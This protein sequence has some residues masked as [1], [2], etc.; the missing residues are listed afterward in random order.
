[1]IS[2]LE[3]LEQHVGSHTQRR[4]LGCDLCAA[5][6]A[7]HGSADLA[8]TFTAQLTSE[9]VEAISLDRAEYEEARWVDP[10][11]IISDTSYHTAVRR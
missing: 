8:M 6:S 11:A 1:M 5:F 3:T 4:E 2:Q 7:D 9:E 10:S